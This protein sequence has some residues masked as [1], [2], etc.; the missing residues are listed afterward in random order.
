MDFG[1]PKE[2]LEDEILLLIKHAITLRWIA[3]VE[4]REMIE[5]KGETP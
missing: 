4:P 3:T 5:P 2:V 1:G